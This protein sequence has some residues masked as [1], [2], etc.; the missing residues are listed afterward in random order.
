MVE[1]DDGPVFEV[2]VEPGEGP[3]TVRL[4]GEL[5]IAAEATLRAALD[6]HTRH[7]RL[8]DVVLDA[9]GLIFADATGLRRLLLVLEGCEPVGRPTLRN[10]D[11]RT[12]L[13]VG[14]TDLHEQLRLD[15]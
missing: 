14:R 12:R 13:V 4:R 9:S 1:P 5:D 10:A 3:L 7:H 15:P 2:E 6:P 11:D 8:G